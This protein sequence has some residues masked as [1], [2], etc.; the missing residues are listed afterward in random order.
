M[1]ARAG[2]RLPSVHLFSPIVVYPVD[3][4]CSPRAGVDACGLKQRVQVQEG[5]A[6]LGE[7][8]PRNFTSARTPWLPPSPVTELGY[9]HNDLTVHVALVSSFYP[10]TPTESAGFS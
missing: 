5:D 2:W 1:E 4:L 8:R 9:R 7:R 6:K 10:K 3:L